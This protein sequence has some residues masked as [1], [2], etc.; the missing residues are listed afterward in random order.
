MRLLPRLIFICISLLSPALAA[1]VVVGF[2]RSSGGDVLLS[3]LHCAN[4]HRSDQIAAHAGPSLAGVG[5]RVRVDF[6]RRWIADPASVKPGT[7]MPALKADAASIEA[8]THFLASLREEGAPARVAGSVERGRHLYHAIGCVAC[9]APDADYPPPG[10]APGTRPPKLEVPSVPLGKPGEKY[11]VASLQSFLLDPLAVR[12]SARMPRVPM[13]DEEAADLAAYLTADAPDPAPF[14]PNARLVAQGRE[15]FASLGCAACHSAPGIEF[16]PTATPLARLTNGGCLDANPPATAPRYDLDDRQRAALSAALAKPAGPSSAHSSMSALNCYACHSRDGQGGP[17][18]GRA[19]YF[20]N[21]GDV[22]LGDEGRIPP[23]LTG[24]GAK[25]Q[26]SVIERV[27]RGD[28]AVRPY[29]ATRMPDFGAAHAAELARVFTETDYRPGEPIPN[30]G[31]NTVGRELIGTAGLTCIACHGLRGRKS[32]GVPAI[33]LMHTTTRLR[34]EWFHAYLRDPGALRPGT[35]MP[36]FWPGG[37]PANP[38][39]KGSAEHQIDS[40]WVYLTELDQSR[41]PEGL[42]EKGQFEIKPTGTPVVFRTFMEDVGMQTIAVGFPQGLH[43][44][45]DAKT[46]R[47]ALAWR[48]AFLDAEGTWEERAA[49]LA[50][51]LGKDVAKLAQAAQ[52]TEKAD[53]HTIFG[54]YRLDARGVP[55]F[56]YR[57][58]ATEVED[59]VEPDAKGRV[60]RRTLTLRGKEPLSFLPAPHEKIVS[61]GAAF[62][63][64]GVAK[65]TTEITW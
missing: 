18:S 40:L 22:D 13:S 48:G 49:P 46:V 44:A 5:S 50:A 53:A 23:P 31:R 51:P 19:A 33:D 9:H 12:P 2:E 20:A 7:T 55:T 26:T 6:L 65:I 41:L 60:L 36:P 27:V 25:L 56:L 14:Q 43:V 17:E 21:V 11:T 39:I 32:L 8:I 30:V 10:L 59:R 54:G 58:G 63:A 62:D 47:L 29:M 16:K 37:K 3:E 34:R 64:Q 24:V 35:R 4:C 28:A 52:F 1:P 45:F 15:K 57:V 42:L 61:G 38:R